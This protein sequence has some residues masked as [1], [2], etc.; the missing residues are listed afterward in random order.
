M[1]DNDIYNSRGRYEK[2]KEKITDYFQPPKGYRKYQ[3]KNSKNLRHFKRLFLKLDA[4]DGSYV[5]RLRLCRTFMMVCHYIGKDF[6]KATREDIDQLMLHAHQHNNSPV[7]KKN[8]VLDLR[9][10]WKLLFPD[11]VTK[12]VNGT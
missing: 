9:F 2:F 1:A 12:R 7:T 4:R 8:H 3:F 6:A 10:I 5:R 11:K